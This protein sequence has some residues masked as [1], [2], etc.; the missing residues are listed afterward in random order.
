[1]HKYLLPQNNSM[2]KIIAFATDTLERVLQA[3]IDLPLGLRLDYF[4]DLRRCFFYEIGRQLVRHGLVWCPY[5]TRPNTNYYTD[6][7]ALW[8]YPQDKTKRKR[9]T[10]GGQDFYSFHAANHNNRDSYETP[11][12]TSVPRLH[13]IGNMMWLAACEQPEIECLFPSGIKVFDYAAKMSSRMKRPYLI[14]LDIQLATQQIQNYIVAHKDA[15]A[16]LPLA[17]RLSDYALRSTYPYLAYSD[18]FIDRYNGET[19]ICDHRYRM[20]FCHEC[21]GRVPKFG[22][23]STFASLYYPYIKPL[24]KSPFDHSQTQKYNDRLLRE[25][26]G[27]PEIGKGVREHVLLTITREIFWPHKV[28]RRARLPELQGLEADIWVPIVNLVIEYQGEQHYQPLYHLG[29]GTML[30]KWQQNDARKKALCHAHNIT[31]LEVRYDESLDYVDIY[32]R[33]RPFS[34]L[35]HGI[36]IT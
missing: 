10:Y 3:T 26:M 33:L 21:T 25:R 32:E 20:G 9:L 18:D 15:L 12:L 6:D 5:E 8:A 13:S 31:M 4:Y 2:K 11:A 35:A 27:Y 36:A 14:M 16:A 30:R 19:Y 28:I 23:S 1:M 22:D 7:D 34:D 17:E 29:G 24:I